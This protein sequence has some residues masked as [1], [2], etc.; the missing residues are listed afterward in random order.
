MKTINIP[1]IDKS[2]DDLVCVKFYRS[3][4][5]KYIIYLQKQEIEGF[6]VPKDTEI[7]IDWSVYI[8]GTPPFSDE[9]MIPVYYVNRMLKFVYLD[10]LRNEK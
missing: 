9:I 8:N 5:R 10:K 7:N 4:S 2:N 3:K 6:V 1:R